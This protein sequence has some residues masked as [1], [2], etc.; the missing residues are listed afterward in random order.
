MNEGER[1][2]RQFYPSTPWI[3]S[4]QLLI[5]VIYEGRYEI[6][7]ENVPHLIEK[8]MKAIGRHGQVGTE[9]EDI[10]EYCLLRTGLFNL[11]DEITKSQLILQKIIF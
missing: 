1:I 3:N 2:L 11:A 4:K 9:A 5:V 7:K 10:K 8:Y 6:P